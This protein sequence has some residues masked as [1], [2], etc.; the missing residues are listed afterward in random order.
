V[1]RS[2]HECLARSPRDEALV[3]MRK[4]SVCSGVTPHVSTGV[5]ADVVIAGRIVGL[6]V[7]AVLL[8]SAYAAASRLLGLQAVPSRTGME[9]VHERLRRRTAEGSGSSRQPSIAEFA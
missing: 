3:T 2:Q 9:E 5:F 7:A 1:F 6:G 8:A 4:W